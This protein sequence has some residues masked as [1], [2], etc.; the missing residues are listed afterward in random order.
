MQLII[1]ANSD[2][3]EE[4]EESKDK[5]KGEKKFDEQDPVVSEKQFVSILGKELNEDK[6]V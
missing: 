6:K 1:G 5:A 3:H 4:S 2:L